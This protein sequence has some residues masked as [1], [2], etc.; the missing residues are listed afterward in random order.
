MPK[1]DRFDR[2]CR[3]QG[4]DAR[5]GP[6]HA[7][8]AAVQRH[9]D[10]QPGD[11]RRARR[12]AHDRRRCLPRRSQ[13][14]QRH[15]RQR[16]VPSRSRRSSTTT[17]SRSASTRSATWSRTAP[18]REATVRPGTSAPAPAGP[19]P[20]GFRTRAA[21][22]LG[23]A[24][25]SVGRHPRAL[26]APPPARAL[27]AEGRHHHRQARRRGRRVTR[28]HGYVVA[29]R[30]RR[31]TLNGEPLGNETV[32]PE[33]RRR[34]RARPARGCS[35]SRRP[36]LVSTRLEPARRDR[37]HAIGAGEAVSARPV[38]KCGIGRLCR[39][40]AGRTSRTR[41]PSRN[42]LLPS[43]NGALNTGSA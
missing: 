21:S 13:Q 9:R 26:A 39:T 10:R 12:A 40:P 8:P 6:H 1:I 27:A 43:C 28:P 18:T 14:H 23:A 32:A 4:G 30:R 22:P 36:E 17:S 3:H 41:L 15:L 38:P 20:L 42:P 11:Q 35:S 31:P 34:A 25:A 7:R 16:H 33:G 37:C 24:G 2:R 5:Q 29:H 19:I